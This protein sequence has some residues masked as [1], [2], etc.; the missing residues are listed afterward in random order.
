MGSLGIFTAW[1]LL[2][3]AGRFVDAKRCAAKCV[4][5][6]FDGILPDGAVIE[7]IASVKEGGSYGEGLHNI[8][9]PTNPTGLPELC[10][11]TVNVTSSAISNYRFGLFLPTASNWESRFLAIGNGGFAG[12]RCSSFTVD[13]SRV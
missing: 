6:T 12:G 9:Y 8:A 11:I 5:S 13:P 10:A 1:A 2:A 4:A 3:L 7:N